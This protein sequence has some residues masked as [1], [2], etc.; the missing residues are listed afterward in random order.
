[1]EQRAGRG[2]LISWF[3]CYNSR[4]PYETKESEEPLST[5]TEDHSHLLNMI[6]D[7]SINAVAKPRLQAATALVVDPQKHLAIIDSCIND[8][9]HYGNMQGVLELLEY[10]REVM[11]ILAF[12]ADEL[13]DIVVKIQELA[14]EL[15]RAAKPAKHSTS[16]AQLKPL[17]RVSNTGRRKRAMSS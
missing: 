3:L 15:F 11:L 13:T 1:M 2:V 5:D 7:L 4:T 8:E 10:R 17:P 12:P 9:D 14:L 6:D 16:E